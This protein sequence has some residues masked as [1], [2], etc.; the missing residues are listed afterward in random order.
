M[1]LRVARTSNHAQIMMRIRIQ[2]R[3]GGG[4]GIVVV[5]G[6]GVSG[7]RNIAHFEVGVSRW[8]ETLKR[9]FNEGIFLV[10][11]STCYQYVS[12]LFFFK[13]KIIPGSLLDVDDG[14]TLKGV[15]TIHVK[16]TYSLS[17]DEKLY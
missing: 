17:K 4:G 14:L 9:Y 8:F 11:L 12:S 1:K 2:V 3:V 5:H 15:H 10:L 7:I 6:G 13:K 16:L